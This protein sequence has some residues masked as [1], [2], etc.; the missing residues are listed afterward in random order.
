MEKILTAILH[1]GPDVAGS[2]PVVGLNNLEV[3]D[4]TFMNDL[5]KKLNNE[6]QLTENAAVGYRTSGKE[7]LDLNF[8]VSSMRNWN[9]IEICKAFTKAYYENSLLAVKWLF[10]LRDIRGN[11]MGERRT[12]RICFK[13]LVENHF[14]KV[15][16]LVELIPE[17]GRYDD[18]LFL[19]D[20]K[21][22]D[23][24]M[25]QIKRQLEVDICNMEQ[26]KEISLLAKWLPSCNAS[27]SQTKLYAKNI[28]KMLGY[29][30]S[31]YRKTLSALRAFLNVVEVKMSAREW[32]AINYSSLPSR[33]NLLYGNAFLRNDEE[34]RREFLSKLSSGEEKINASTLFPSDIV[35]KYYGASKRYSWRAKLSDRNETLEGLWEALPDYVGQDSSTLVV[36][37]GSGSMQTKVGNTS[38]TALNVSTA[39]AIYF[40]EHLKGQFY[41]KFIT[42][43][44]RP[45]MIDMSNATSLRDKLEIC[46]D[47]ADCSN[48]NLKAVFDLILSTA[49]SNNL[50][51]NELPKNILIVSDMEF[52][53][54][55]GIYSRRGSF[56][57]E[58]SSTKT[59]LES[60]AAEYQA[61]G[62]ILPRL[63][64]WNVCSRTNTIPL[65]E[66]EAGVALVS[67][68]NPA[69]YNMVLSNELDPYK[70]LL[71]QI[72]SER[73]AAIEEAFIHQIEQEISEE[74]G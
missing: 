52:D 60:I 53:S 6:K 12:F 36:R 16:S 47:H 49:I 7:L 27:S 51:Q 39:L 72:N 61:H 23:I 64:F 55:M 33:A 25:S 19:L 73:Y 32:S 45:E 58:G 63:I 56:N 31:E 74:E 29:K 1:R 18:W 30:E 21:A 43:S 50:E 44:S 5:E 35:H 62:Y 70:C 3:N 65:Q 40:A 41:N 57:Q 17:Y 10:Y 59:L 15:M 24:V 34:R 42:F 20:S 22:N 26:G 66:N 69:V 28:C 71:A 38:V 68:F 11:G 13:W 4:M 54:M 14:D 67:G 8:A 46:D 2:I 37:D 9:E 48:T